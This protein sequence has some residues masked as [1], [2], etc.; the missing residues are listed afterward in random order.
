M[1]PFPSIPASGPTA[2]TAVITRCSPG[3]SRATTIACMYD[4][5]RRGGQ[6][7]GTTRARDPSTNK[8]AQSPRCEVE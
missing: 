5:H 3:I 4:R 1:I 2:R 6:I 7:L 8:Q